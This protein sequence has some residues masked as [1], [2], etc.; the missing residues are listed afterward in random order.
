MVFADTTYGEYLPVETD[1]YEAD[2]LIRDYISEADNSAAAWLAEI[3]GRQSARKANLERDEEGRVVVHV[4]FGDLWRRKQHI[5]RLGEGLALVRRL[6]IPL[7]A[8]PDIFETRERELAHLAATNAFR[9]D[10]LYLTP[11][12]LSG[13]F[14]NS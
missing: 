8:N 6:S 5:L 9:R 13:L 1:P 2:F 12:Q 4:S 3:F 14:P 7:S 10:F 11:P